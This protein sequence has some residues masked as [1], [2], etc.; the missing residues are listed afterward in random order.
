MIEKTTVYTNDDNQD[1]CF[2]TDKLECGTTFYVELIGGANV[3]YFSDMDE[4]DQFC[5]LLNKEGAK[6]FKGCE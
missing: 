1:L 3:L 4:I 6:F 2:N 5:A